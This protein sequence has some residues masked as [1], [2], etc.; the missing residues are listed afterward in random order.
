MEI[1]D[2]LMTPPGL[3]LIIVLILALRQIDKN[4]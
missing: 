1:I 2:A 3:M 4:I